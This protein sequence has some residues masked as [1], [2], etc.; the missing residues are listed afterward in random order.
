MERLPVAL[1]EPEVAEP[2]AEPYLVVG[3]QPVV[4][5]SVAEPP[6]TGPREVERVSEELVAAALVEDPDFAA[7]LVAEPSPMA[8]H[9]RLEEVDLPLQQ[10]KGLSLN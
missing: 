2:E 10:R 5:G 4:G 3:V 6:G 9:A 7:G 1:A 8:S